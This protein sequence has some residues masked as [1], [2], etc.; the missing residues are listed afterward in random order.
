MHFNLPP[1]VAPRLGL[2]L[3]PL[4]VDLIVLVRWHWK[5]ISELVSNLLKILLYKDHSLKKPN[6][7]GF[8]WLCSF[9]MVFDDLS[10]CGHP[11]AKI[12]T[13]WESARECPSNVTKQ[14]QFYYV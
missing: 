12:F 4:G 8:F 6:F 11:R 2:L 13:E 9:M 3:V 10:C 1:G 7:K 5:H 14:L